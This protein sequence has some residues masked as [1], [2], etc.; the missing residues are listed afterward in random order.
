MPQHH[1]PPKGTSPADWRFPARRCP[2][3]SRAPARTVPGRPAP[4][5]GAREH[6]DRAGQ[7]RGLVGEDV[8]EQVLGEDHVEV[9]RRGDELHRGV[10][11][12]HVLELDVRELLRVH[13]HHRLA[14]QPAG[15][16]HVGLVD[17]R[18]ARARG[19]EADAGD[20][21]DLLDRV[22]AEVARRS[23]PCAASRRSRSRRSARARPA[24]RCP[25][26]ARAA[27]ARRRTAPGSGLTG[28]RLA[29]RP[30][31]LRRPSSPCSGRGA[32]G[33]VVSHF[34]PPTAASSTA[35]ARRQASSTSSVSAVPC[36]SIEAPP[37]TC[38]SNSNSPS[39]R[40]QLERRAP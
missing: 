17:A 21:L 29:Y 38:S 40:E 30:R 22:G 37:K 26:S 35:S 34:G 23:R 27:A 8:A 9:A 10:V 6:P 13:A 18:D 1:A 14:P 5:R 28:R 33:S 24:D 20:P 7:H 4:E 3:R 31:P 32:S 2:A 15:L 25:R 19:A 36:A 11:D 12:E 39:A 16:Q